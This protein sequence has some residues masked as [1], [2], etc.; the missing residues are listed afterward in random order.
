MKKLPASF[1]N[2]FV[3]LDKQD[4][5]MLRDIFQENIRSLK[6]DI[7]DEMGSLIAASER[8]VIEGVAE[9][10]DVSLLPQLADLQHDVVRIKTH[11]QL[12]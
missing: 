10:L 12:T 2:V 6:R 11:I 5:A 9:L 8:R 7:R 4:I 3:M 1:I